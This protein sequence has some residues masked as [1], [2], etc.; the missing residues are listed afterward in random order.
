MSNADEARAWKILASAELIVSSRRI[1]LAIDDLASSI[2][3]DFGKSCPY[4]LI[5]MNG[6]VFLAGQ[7]LPR[8]MM[9][10]YVGHVHVSRYGSSLSGGE[11]SWEGM[12]P[13]EIK[14]KAVLVLDDI[15]DRGYT[16]ASIKQRVL[17]LGAESFSCAVLVDKTLQVEKPFTPD[18]IG[19][20]APDKFL[21]GCGMDVDGFW[22]NMT[23]IYAV[24]ED[25]ECTQS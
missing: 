25:H 2:S 10:M 17:E 13:G 16:M 9:P 5:A 19:V 15:F 6:G 12:L 24:G 8:L 11:V 21:F 20:R 7:L 22:R 4:V 3:K 1:Q 14:G 18:Y 23:E